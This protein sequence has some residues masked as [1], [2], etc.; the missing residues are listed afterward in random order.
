[1]AVT[2]LSVDVPARAAHEILVTERGRF[3]ELLAELGDDRDFADL[4]S[5]DRHGFGS[6]WALWR[7]LEGIHGL[8]RT[9]V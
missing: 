1:M 9:K 2:L 4:E 6:A 5:V 7:A 3:N 8:G